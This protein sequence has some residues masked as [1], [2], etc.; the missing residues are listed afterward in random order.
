M[1]HKNSNSRQF[2][3]SQKVPI[4]PVQLPKIGSQFTGRTTLHQK[5]WVHLSASAILLPALYLLS[6]WG[7][8]QLQDIEEHV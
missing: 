7:N 2:P 1:P 3:D 4:A 5:H 8:R 6:V